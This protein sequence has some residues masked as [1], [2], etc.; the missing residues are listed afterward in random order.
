MAFEGSY[1]WQLRQKI[2]T[3]LV[4]V[5]AAQVLVFD[6]AERL[7]LMLRSDTRRWGLP[8]GCAEPGSTFALTAV[9]E[10]EEETGL[11]V[12]PADLEPFGCVS[13]PE[14]HSVTYP[15]GDR[16]HAFAMCFAARTWSGVPEPRDGEALELSFFA[17]LP[18]QRHTQVDES[19]GLWRAY[20]ETGKFQVS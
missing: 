11:S 12:A 5:P 3:E 2:G 15:N 14:L 18:E 13:S 4:L 8:A 10:L 9:R 6:D 16:I 1:L 17:T 7:L 19:I 20:K